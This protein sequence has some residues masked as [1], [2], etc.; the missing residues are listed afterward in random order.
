MKDADDRDLSREIP[1]DVEDLDLVADVE[2]RGC[3]VEEQDL[4]FL[5][6]RPGNEDALA[7]AAADAVHRGP[8]EVGDVCEVHGM[9]ADLH[10]PRRLGGEPSDVGVPAHH[11]DVAHR[12]VETDRDVLRD[13][14]DPAREFAVPER[15]QVPVVKPD[16]AVVPGDDPAHRF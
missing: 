16:L 13:Y 5:C 4:R 15:V 11:D 9:V 6:E 10:V 8:G 14:R 1:D 12:I 3:F 2:V 7:F